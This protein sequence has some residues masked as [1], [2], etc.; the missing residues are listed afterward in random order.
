MSLEII[1]ENENISL[2]LNNGKEIIKFS[3]LKYKE[4]YELFACKSSY[5]VYNFVRLGLSNPDDK[6]ILKEF[7]EI[8]S[9]S[10]NIN[11]VDYIPV[12]KDDTIENKL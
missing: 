2:E 10:L 8:I 11:K 12:L 6:E 7:F 4:E 5:T 1:K 9:N 3:L